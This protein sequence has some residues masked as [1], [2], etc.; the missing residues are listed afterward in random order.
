[1]NTKNWSLTISFIVLIT[2]GY[3][4]VISAPNKKPKE[5]AW[6]KIHTVNR[7]QPIPYPSVR[8]A[9]IVWSKRVW[10][11]IDLKEKLN[12]PL[13]YPKT[14]VRDKKSLASILINAATIPMTDSKAIQLKYGSEYLAAYTDESLTQ[15]YATLDELNDKLSYVIT[16]SKRDTITGIVSPVPDT[17]LVRSE[18]ITKYALMEDWFFDK[19]RSQLDV[20]IRAICPIYYQK[21]EINGV[22]QPSQSP[23]EL[24]WVYFPEARFILVNNECYNPQNDAEWR[25]FDDIF[26][27]RRFSSYIYKVENVYD[28]SIA[29]YATG[30]DALLESERIKNEIFQFEQDLWEY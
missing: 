16:I 25:N 6:E 13:F 27:K 26:T 30:L 14:P 23:S 8:E 3:S 22:I 5:R 15:Q 19:K 29:E 11:F 21:R 28:R 20:R 9:D 12:L 4:Q 24:F 18:D 7:K 1:M 10:R 17:N 2:V